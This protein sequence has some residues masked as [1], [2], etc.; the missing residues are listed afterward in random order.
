MTVVADV[1]ACEYKKRS[2]LIYCFIRIPCKR[3]YLVTAH[4]VYCVLLL[5]FRV[6]LLLILQSIHP[7]ISRYFA[8]VYSAFVLRPWPPF[9]GR[10]AAAPPYSED[11]QQLLFRR[12]NSAANFR[13]VIN[14]FCPRWK[15]GKGSVTLPSPFL[16]GEGRA[17]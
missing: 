7:F 13:H 6:K 2:I 14:L 4:C 1:G 9:C 11:G 3:L 12:G 5:F 8:R 17:A 15:G 16:G 10:A